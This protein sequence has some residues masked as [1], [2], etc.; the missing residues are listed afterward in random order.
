MARFG[1]GCPCCHWCHE[2]L[3]QHRLVCCLWIGSIVVVVVVVVVVAAVGAG[4]GG[5]DGETIVEGT[6]GRGR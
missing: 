1:S 4:G 3:W 2:Q 6:H 5:G